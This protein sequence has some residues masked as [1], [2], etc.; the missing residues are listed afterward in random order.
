MV[1]L[2]ALSNEVVQ[3]SFETTSEVLVRSAF[4][5]CEKNRPTSLLGVCGT[6]QFVT[7]FRRTEKKTR[8]CGCVLPVRS[9]LSAPIVRSYS[10]MR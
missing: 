4:D 10:G 2:P 7:L 5:E 6:V 1:K 3:T 8:F 9:T